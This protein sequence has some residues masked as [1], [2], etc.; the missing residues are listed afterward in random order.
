M[1]LGLRYGQDRPEG[2][3]EM[4]RITREF[5]EIFKAR[6]GAL[7]CSDILGFDIS[8]PQGLQAARDKN[9]F[10]TVCPLLVD[11]TARALERYLSEHPDH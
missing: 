6:H 3:E 11:A 10:A 2:K 7:R 5:M 8:T 1:V 4:Y 9:V